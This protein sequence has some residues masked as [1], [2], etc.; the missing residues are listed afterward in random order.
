MIIAGW[1]NRPYSRWQTAAIRPVRLPPIRNRL[2]LIPAHQLAAMIRTRSCTSEQVIGAYVERC[3]Q[4]NALLNAIVDERFD[5]ALDEARA[6]DRL[7]ASGTRT[8]AQ[9]AAE[10]PLLGLPLTVKESIAV[11][12]LSNQAGRV[13]PVP[14][15]AIADAPAVQR[16]RLAG[17]IVLCVTNTP[18]LCMCW[19]TYNNRTGLTHNPYDVRR[20][21]GGSSGGEAALLA[22]GASLLGVC[23]DVAGSSR[24]PSSFC[25]VYGHKP[26]PL[27]VSPAGHMPGSTAPF[28]GQ[29]FTLAPMCRY[30]SDLQLLLRCIADPERSILSPA[31]GDE[32]AVDV[33]SLR[34]FYMLD[35]GP[36]GLMKP[37]NAEIRTAILD[38]AKLWQGQ[39]THLAE[40]QW[41]LE[42][43]MSAMLRIPEVE[44]IYYRPD[45]A[46]DE[47]MPTPLSETVRYVLGR[48][49]CTFPSV[50]VGILQAL[51]AALPEAHHRR[52]AEVA[53]RLRER[54]GELLGSDGVFLYPTFSGTAHRH[55]EIYHKLVEPS[56]MMVFNTLGMPVTSCAVRLSSKGMPIGIQVSCRWML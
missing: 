3:R 26:S 29:F 2:L 6:I 40:L 43:S 18:E 9:M 5:A 53:Q 55:Y 30:A 11:A 49:E 45:A 37:V 22:A 52:M 54:F 17:A 32:T 25:G 28:W 16:A 27:A 24:L 44:T 42:M 33:R 39:P 13:L 51:M 38:V 8:V 7:I 46:A 34:M 12:G 14:H 21:A 36:S 20:T 50:A 41:S 31:I 56:F 4:V 10:Q 1:L 15:C 48:S 47:Q 23:S 19:E 35:D